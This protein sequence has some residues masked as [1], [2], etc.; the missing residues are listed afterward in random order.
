MKEVIKNYKSVIAVYTITLLVSIGVTAYY[1]SVKNHIAELTA[2]K[3]K[4]AA[5]NSAVEVFL[6]NVK[7]DDNV[8]IQT[9]NS[10]QRRD[11]L[12]K[13][14]EERIANYSEGLNVKGDIQPGL[15][16]QILGSSVDKIIKDL[17][18]QQLDVDPKEEL[19]FLST[20]NDILKKGGPEIQIALQQLNYVDHVLKSAANAGLEKVLSIKRPKDLVISVEKDKNL[21]WEYHSF[22]FKFLGSPESVKKLINQLANEKGFY[23]RISYVE[24]KGQGSIT[25]IVPTMK[26]PAPLAS[27]QTAQVVNPENLLIQPTEAIKKE[28]KAEEAPAK[29]TSAE[30]QKLP[31]N[32][33]AF[34]KPKVEAEIYVDW[35]IFKKDQKGK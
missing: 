9:K 28:I 27:T 10:E 24:F 26:F 30:Q 23:S 17:K 2:T 25:D 34:E 12:K 32:P 33:L 11:E 3:T 8:N 20:R 6:P 21:P 19:S 1:F 7:N 15:A 4:I 29:E 5:D 18:K 16:K 35:I 31:T 22:Q 13:I 14:K